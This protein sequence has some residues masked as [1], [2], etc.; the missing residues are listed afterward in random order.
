MARAPTPWLVPPFA[1]VGL[2]A[3]AVVVDAT[4]PNGDLDGLR[5]LYASLGAIAGTAIGAIVHRSYRRAACDAHGARVRVALF[6]VLAGALIAAV[7][8]RS[9]DAPVP[10]QEFV[11]CGALL[12][13]AF[14]PVL[15]FA[16]GAAVRAERARLGSI[17]AGADRRAVW[18]VAC[19]ALSPLTLAAFPAWGWYAEGRREAPIVAFGVA[20][21]GAFVALAGV[22]FETR[23]LRRAELAAR[24]AGA[25][26]T[27][28]LVAEDAAAARVDLGVGDDLYARAEGG[29]ET[30]RARARVVEL[31]LGDPHEALA[32]LRRARV[33]AGVFATVAL[34]SALVH[35]ARSMNVPLIDGL[36][37]EPL[38]TGAIDLAATPA[39]GDPEIDD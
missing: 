29:A 15:L 17:V 23:S 4:I 35:G 27:G 39:M 16:L 13:I 25:L 34:A 10:L 19:G 11:A 26:H 14:L 3:G 6:G 9:V 22:L 2:A 1:L 12:A 30:Y 28:P 33:R 31:V 7:V 5:L 37:V 8:W 24:R 18:I 38:W 21:A 32:A 36:I 20:A